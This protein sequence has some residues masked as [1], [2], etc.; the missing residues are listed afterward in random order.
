MDRYMKIRLARR[1]S[2]SS[3]WYNRTLII[4]LALPS[5]WETNSDEQDSVLFGLKD[6]SQQSPKG[7]EAPYVHMSLLFLGADLLE[8]QETQ[9][10]RAV[11]LYIYCLGVYR[12]WKHCPHVFGRSSSP[13]QRHLWAAISTPKHYLRIIIPL[14]VTSNGEKNIR[15]CYAR[16]TWLS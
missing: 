14:R 11:L 12:S 5:S 10:R 15:S 8:L 9:D 2:M 16:E 13:R 6:P 4:I 1:P 3:L 7:Q